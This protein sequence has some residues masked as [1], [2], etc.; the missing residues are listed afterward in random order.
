[1]RGTALQSLCW[2]CIHCVPKIYKN[3]Y[4]RGCEWSI[5]K[6][7]VKGWT[8]IPTDRIFFKSFHVVHCPKFERGRVTPPL[9]G[10]K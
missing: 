5:D 2:D 10:N 9:E 4:I 3:E 6:E 1:M 7:P 8:A